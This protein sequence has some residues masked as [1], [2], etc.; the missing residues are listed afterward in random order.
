VAP[1]F[2]ASRAIVD[3]RLNPSYGAGVT[4]TIPLTFAVGRGNLRSA[5]LQREQADAALTQLQANIALSVATAEGQVETTRRR[6]T[7]DEA[8]LELAKQDLAAEEKKLKAGMSS[9]NYVVQK[10]QQLAQ[11]ETSLSNALAAERQAIAT[12]DH[13]LG[14]TLERH[15]I[16]LADE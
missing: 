11:D 13:E 3:Q 5:R 12:Y 10:Q 16:K 14:T 8:A 2:S 7:A 15:K 6:V 4:V 1:S 9:T